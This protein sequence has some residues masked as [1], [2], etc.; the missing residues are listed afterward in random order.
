MKLNMTLTRMFAQ[1]IAFSALIIGLASAVSA[2]G[3]FT[4][5]G[6][7][8]GFTDTTF[9]VQT[10]S[11]IYDIKKSDLSQAQL[12]ELKKKKTGQEVDLI[13]STEAIA[14]VRDVK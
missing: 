12:E 8:K 10:K 6:K 2:S 13:V 5:R 3:I 14:A 1:V 11:V 9:I 4:L 7:L